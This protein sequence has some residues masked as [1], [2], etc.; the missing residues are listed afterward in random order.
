[1]KILHDI[2]NHS[3]LSSCCEDFSATTENFVKKE[4]DMGMRTYGLSNHIWDESIKGASNWYSYQT[5]T[6]AREAKTALKY[7]PHDGLKCI[8]GAETEYYGCYDKLGMSRE[9]AKNFEY[10]L[11]PFSHTHMVN[12]VMS[13]YPEIT[14]MRR[15]LLAKAKEAWQFLDEKD[16]ENI[17]NG[18]NWR[19][20]KKYL[21]EIKTDSV[22]YSVKTL[23][24]NSRSLVENEDFRQLCRVMP[25]SV[26]HPYALC[27]TTT[28]ERQNVLRA[29]SSEDYRRFYR[30]VKKLG[31][32]VEINVSSVLEAGEE[33]ETNPHL[34][35]FRIA[36][37]EGC[38]FTFGTDAHSTHWLENIRIGDRIS[39]LL[40]LKRSDIA[41]YLQDS[42]I[43]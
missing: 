2:H 15:E 3:V 30:E 26:A 12:F 33:L 7:I 38:Q 20:V 24:R 35:H 14:E 36:K 25:V 31:A 21:P 4:M 29:I 10:L 5:I 18:M 34:D 28:E 27:G 17:F 13:E 40:E 9:G 1:M 22:D 8:F 23:I 19:T 16:I 32:Y 41:D 43:E 6:K 42:V 37:E 11:V 39:E